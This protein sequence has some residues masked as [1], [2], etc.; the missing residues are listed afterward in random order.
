MKRVFGSFN[1]SVLAAGIGV[2]MAHVNAEAG[3]LHPRARSSLKTAGSGVIVSEFMAANRS[4]LRDSDGDRSDWIEVLNQ[5][6]TRVQL[7]GW[8]LSDRI[9]VPTR[10]RFPAVTLGPGQRLLVFASGK[11]R[12]G[13]ELHCSFRLD[14]EGEYLGLFDAAGRVVDEFR[15]TF[16]AQ[17]EDVSFGRPGDS[18][19]SQ[20]LAQ[21]TPGT[22]NSGPLLPP[23]EG[24]QVLP[25]SGLYD[26]PVAVSI[27]GGSREQE[28]WVTVDGSEPIPGMG[29]ANRWSGTVRLTNSAVIRVI[30][31]QPGHAPSPVLTRTYIQTSR[32]A[33][34]PEGQP[35]LPSA[36]SG[37]P[38][39]YDVD[40]DRIETTGVYSLSNS[41]RSL[42]AVF[43]TLSHSEWWDASRGIYVNSLLNGR[44]WERDGAV[45]MTGVPGVEGFALPATVQIS[46]N[47]SRN[48]QFTPK[49]SLRLTFQ[50]RLGA[51]HLSYPL[52]PDSPLDRFDQLSLR[53]CYTDAWTATDIAPDRFVPGRAT[54]LRDQWM[55]DAIRDIGQPAARSR[56]VHVFL[57]TLYWGLYV[58]TER[59][60]DDWNAALFGG[61]KEEYDIIKDYAELE[62]GSLSSWEQLMTAAAGVRT[63]A[64]YFRLQGRTES[65]AR[66]RSLPVLLEMTNF[67]DYM[68]LHIYA[69]AEDWPGH[70]WWASRRR[71]DDSEGFRFFV[72]DQEIS[73]ESL[74]RETVY[75]AQ[76]FEEVM[77]PASP[78]ILY[79]RLRRTPAFRQE[80]IDR[81]ETL[82][83]GEGLLTPLANHRR[84]IRR[85]DEIDSAVVAESARWGDVRKTP[86]FRRDPDWLAEMA[87]VAGYWVPN[88]ER[89]LERFRRVGL[90]SR[91]R[92]PAVRDLERLDLTNP[93]D[94]GSLWFT[95][96]GTDPR[97]LLGSPSAAAR[98]YVGPESLPESAVIVARILDQGDWSAPLRIGFRENPTLAIRPIGD[99]NVRLT[100]VVSP[101]PGTGWFLQES[102][103]P[104]GPWIPVPTASALSTTSA[105]I[106][107][108]DANSRAKFFR[109]AR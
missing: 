28:F 24:F 82:L 57:N 45:E 65:G 33:T 93:N 2:L 55:R 77:M 42:P 100:V 23:I 85:Q 46:G 108:L 26:E 14:A 86:G 84:W 51:S 64:D 96:D 1:L 62:S 34:Q 13:G 19:P 18:E 79:D 92:P 59:M 21:P 15:P 71:G 75:W 87:W 49:H 12:L 20:S 91:L 53:A 5:S 61:R 40:R 3:G 88:H 107:E 97:G 35:R 73:N 72:W 36:W 37:V 11:N 44:E 56:Y 6:E 7:D 101:V 76:R 60:D 94:A 68:A 102:M 52:F 41:L 43:L 81:L 78:G 80:C 17:V 103:T 70:N 22:P 30:A 9:D 50:A 29:T 95:T 63:D 69:G 105:T 54:Y 4:G 16:P 89:A 104:S 83:F 31:V 90:V 10:W 25:A 38:A 74:T 32:I 48:P 66:D 39:R 47:S 98:R 58:M 8:S 67:I 106:V 27:A 109:A 99:G